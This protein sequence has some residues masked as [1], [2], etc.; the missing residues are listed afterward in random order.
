MDPK[1]LD[2]KKF[3][4]GEFEQI[5]EKYSEQ[6]QIQ[7]DLMKAKIIGQNINQCKILESLTAIQQ[8]P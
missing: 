5:F 8:S 3:L 2:T 6:P 7:L 1:I 4:E